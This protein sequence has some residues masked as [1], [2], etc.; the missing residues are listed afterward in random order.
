MW[1]SLA[2]FALGEAYL[3][4]TVLAPDK[5]LAPVPLE[6]IVG[7]LAGAA[8]FFGPFGMAAGTGLGLVVSALVRRVRR[9]A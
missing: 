2:G 6:G 5:S 3:I 8:F 1:F 9:K 7:R 4:Y